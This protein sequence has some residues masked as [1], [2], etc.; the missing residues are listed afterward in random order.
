VYGICMTAGSRIIGSACDGTVCVTVLAGFN[1]LAKRRCKVRESF[2]V[3]CNTSQVV[4][5]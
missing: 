3:F 5:G 2:V 4:S 1:L